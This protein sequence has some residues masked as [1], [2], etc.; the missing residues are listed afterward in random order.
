M[1]YAVLSSD[2]A[3][4][5]LERMN[6]FNNRRDPNYAAQWETDLERALQELTVFPSPLSHARDEE[7]SAYYGREVRWMLYYGPTKR[8][9]GT[10][11]RILFTV[12]PPDPVE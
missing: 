8:R 2:P 10:P 4:A 5:D 1:N 3:D 7:A 11:V 6:V 12:L 9:T